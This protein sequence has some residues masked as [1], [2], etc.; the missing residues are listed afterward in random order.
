M[1]TRAHYLFLNKDELG[2]IIYNTAIFKNNKKMMHFIS[3]SL[4]L[5]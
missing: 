4:I 2:K 1:I 5:G 3:W